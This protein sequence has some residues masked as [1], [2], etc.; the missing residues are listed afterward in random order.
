MKKVYYFVMLCLCALGFIG[1]IGYSVYCGAWY[2]VVGVVA[3]GYTAWPKF[4]G[5]FKILSE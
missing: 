3:L 5:Y 1:G 4:V 2:V